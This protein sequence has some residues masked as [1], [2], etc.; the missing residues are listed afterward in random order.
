MMSPRTPILPGLRG[1]RVFE[2]PQTPK[3]ARTSQLKMIHQFNAAAVLNLTTESEI[4]GGI[5]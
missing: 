3:A 2:E 1:R 4:V 5:S